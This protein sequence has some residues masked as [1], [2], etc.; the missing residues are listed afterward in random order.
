MADPGALLKVLA[1]VEH[2]FSHQ[3][4]SADVEQHTTKNNYCRY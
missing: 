2:A 1:P 4:Q 3:H